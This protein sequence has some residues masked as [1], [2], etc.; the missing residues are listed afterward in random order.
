MDEVIK[1]N[2]IIG[3]T[4]NHLTNTAQIEGLV[5]NKSV[6]IKMSLLDMNHVLTEMK[7]ACERQEMSLSREESKETGWEPSEARRLYH[8][9]VKFKSRWVD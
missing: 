6:T 5:G 4:S 3:I 8:S 9:K 1:L 2:R 7:F